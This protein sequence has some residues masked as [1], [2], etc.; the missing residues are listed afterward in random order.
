L[1]DSWVYIHNWIALWN[2]W[3]GLVGVLV[4]KELKDAS[5]HQ[6]T[7]VA[8]SGDEEAKRLYGFNEATN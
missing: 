3:L 5:F 8:V 1:H 2:L 4:L 6:T 7:W